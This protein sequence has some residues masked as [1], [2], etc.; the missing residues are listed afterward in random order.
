MRY[1]QTPVVLFPKRNYLKRE[2]KTLHPSAAKVKKACRCKPAYLPICLRKVRI[3]TLHYST[4][5]ERKL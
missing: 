3:G 4:R 1:A 2:T 5:T